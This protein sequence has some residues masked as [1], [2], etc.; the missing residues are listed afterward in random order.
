M[1]A[2]R[3]SEMFFHA[4]DMRNDLTRL[5][6]NHGIADAHVLAID[7]LGIVQARTAYGRAGDLDRLQVSHRRDRPALAHLHANVFDPRCGLVF[8][9][10]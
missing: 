7:L 9:E 3:P 4:D 2:A 10:L 1:S 8:L 5:F 6:D